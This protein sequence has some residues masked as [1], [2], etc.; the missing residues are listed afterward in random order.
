MKKFFKFTG[1]LIALC[2]SVVVIYYFINNEALPKGE[3]G[4]K[5]DALAFKMLVALN[6]STYKNTNILEWSFK[7][8]HHYKWLKNENIVY[9]SWDKNKVILNTNN[10]ENSKVF[11]D[12]NKVENKEILQKAI[13]YF[14]NDSFWLVAPY[15]VFDTGTERRIVNYNG[16][17]ALLIT[18][19]SG[20]STPGDSYLWFVNENYMPT[21][22]KMWTSII[23][24]GGLEATWSDWTQT[25]ANI[26]LPKKHRLSL[27]NIEISMG[28]VKA[29]Y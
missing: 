28:N 29:Y 24:I 18:Y 19:T 16:N 15:K 2:I 10:P 1:I 13:K 6:N 12:R 7:N 5:A 27:F 17:E 26:Q 4:L 20:G 14:N 25:E 21:S 3:K 8:E 22:F 23:P 11:V 9:V